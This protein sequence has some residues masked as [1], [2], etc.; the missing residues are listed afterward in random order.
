MVLKRG[1]Y[2]FWIA[3]T[4]GFTWEISALPCADSGPVGEGA[5]ITRYPDNGFLEVENICYNIRLQG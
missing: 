3:G 5:A 2:G 4:D 1:R